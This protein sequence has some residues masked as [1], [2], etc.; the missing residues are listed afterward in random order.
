MVRS[1]K[2]L[3]VA[4]IVFTLSQGWANT[5]QL[6]EVGNGK[7]TW[8]GIKVYDAKLLA[9][10]NFDGDFKKSAP[11]ALEILYDMDIDSSDLVETT[12][13]EWEEIAIGKTNFCQG[14]KL[15]SEQ[16]LDIWPDL[17]EG[18]RLKLFVDEERSSTFYHNDSVI[19]SIKDPNFSTCFLAIWLAEDSSAQDLREDLLSL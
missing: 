2:L 16:L 3:I 19:G 15:W 7:Y 17:K 5:H 6:T 1:Y 4:S 13:D 10:E 9:G 8:F 18:D 12:N 14:K 11:L